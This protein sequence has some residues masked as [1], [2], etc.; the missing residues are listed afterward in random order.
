MFLRAVDEKEIPLIYMCNL[1]F[2]TG[3]FANKMKIGLVIPLYKTWNKCHF[4]NYRPLSILP[5]FSKILEKL[6]NNRLDA[7]LEKQKLFTGSQYGFRA[8]RSLALL[9]LIEEI[10]KAID[11]KK[12]Q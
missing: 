3:S 12:L 1:S 10:T 4:T 6:S 5:H 8:N 9:D 7:F 2:Q 11:C